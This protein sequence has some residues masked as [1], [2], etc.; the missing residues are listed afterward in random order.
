MSPS[1]NI[2]GTCPPC[3]IL[4]DA[5]G[6]N[7][8]LSLVSILNKRKRQQFET[9]LSFVQLL[10]YKVRLLSDLTHCLSYCRCI[11]MAL[12]IQQTGIHL[13]NKR[14]IDV[15]FPPVH[16]ASGQFACLEMNFAVLTY[17]EVKLAFVSPADNAY[18]ELLIFRSVE[19]TSEDFRPWE[20][21]ITPNATEGQAFVV[22]L[23]S[24]G[25]SPGT[26]V[27]IQSINLRMLPCIPSGNNCVFLQ[28]QRC[29]T[30][31]IVLLPKIRLRLCCPKKLNH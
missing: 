11:D 15:F 24:E 29:K 14:E 26:M 30:F 23:H 12:K 6:G 20:S 28:K 4:I 2:G 25:T 19:S 10:L 21:T 31:V 1:P 27:M 22:V 18:K 5:P 13:E 16:L 3:P 9:F 8:S 17:F 7:Y